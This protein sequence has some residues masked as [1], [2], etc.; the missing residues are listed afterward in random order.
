M[1]QGDVGEYGS[2]GEQVSFGFNHGFL[3]LYQP[4]SV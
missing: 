4:T 3:Y 1:D 2:K